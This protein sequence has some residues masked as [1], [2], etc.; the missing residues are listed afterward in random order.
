MMNQKKNRKKSKALPITRRFAKYLKRTLGKYRIE[1][2][3]A[4]NTFEGF[5]IDVKCNKL[6]MMDSGDPLVHRNKA[7]K[8]KC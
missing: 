3:Q 5:D 2:E 1:Q 7:G 4:C 6:A 8:K